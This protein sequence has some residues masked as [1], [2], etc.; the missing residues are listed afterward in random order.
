MIDNIKD[1]YTILGLTPN[2][3]DEEIR[4]AYIKL[5]KV[6]HPDHNSDMAD[7]RM[8]ELNQAYEVLSNTS[9]KKE[10]DIRFV[11]NQSLDFTHV[12][13]NEVAR[14]KKERVVKTKGHGTISV[15]LLFLGILWIFVVY[16]ALYFI[17]NMAIMYVDLPI[18]LTALFPQ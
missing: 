13:K 16:L 12:Q 3:S 6:Y 8:I 14:Q 5:A 11:K 17:I 9:K 10:Y 18:W 7:R 1:Y 4:K 2:A 15:R